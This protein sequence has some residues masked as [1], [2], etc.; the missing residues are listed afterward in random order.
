MGC[1]VPYRYAEQRKSANFKRRIMADTELSEA[2][3]DSGAETTT[4]GITTLEELTASFVEKVEEAEPSQES[5][6]EPSPE[7]S[8]R[9]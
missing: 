2:P 6:A 8:N 4:Q 7:T 5:E 9:S 3:A 1:G